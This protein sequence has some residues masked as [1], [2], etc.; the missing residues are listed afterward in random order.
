MAIHFGF[1]AWKCT[2]QFS[3]TVFLLWKKSTF[4]HLAMIQKS[5]FKH[6]W[7][8]QKHMY[9]CDAIFMVLFEFIVS[10]LQSNIR[11]ILITKNCDMK[12]SRCFTLRV[13]ITPKTR[14]VSSDEKN[15]EVAGRTAHAQF[16]RSTIPSMLFGSRESRTEGGQRD[17]NKQWT[18]TRYHRTHRHVNTHTHTNTR[19]HTH[20][21][22]QTHAYTPTQTHAYT[23]T[24]THTQT[25]AYTHTYAHSTTHTHTAVLYC[26]VCTK[27]RSVGRSR[28][29]V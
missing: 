17:V 1:I 25:H 5:K 23:H 21:H 4:C 26:T 6:L 8:F 27:L 24:H 28:S 29:H 22:T 16:T 11:A 3:N 2:V 14:D 12:T 19:I 7:I 10:L 20:T 18:M 13:L 15:H 9:V